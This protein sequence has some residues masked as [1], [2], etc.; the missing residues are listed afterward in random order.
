M[1]NVGKRFSQCHMIFWLRIREIV[2]ALEEYNILGKNY[3]F[4]CIDQ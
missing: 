3:D 1:F 2:G 4:R